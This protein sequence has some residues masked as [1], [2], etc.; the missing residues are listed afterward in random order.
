MVERI[1]VGVLHGRPGPTITMP[2]GLNQHQS[3]ALQATFPHPAADR[4]PGEGT[5]LVEMC[6]HLE[7]SEH[8]HDRWRNINGLIKADD[9]KR[10]KELEKEN[11]RW[12][13]IVADQPLEIDML[14]ELNRGDS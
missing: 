2:V 8:T 1:Y 14:K 7:V 4:L 10:L 12:R 3:A 9:A 6:K 13:W 5:S 11:A